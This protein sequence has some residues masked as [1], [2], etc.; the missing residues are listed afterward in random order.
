MARENIIVI[1][2]SSKKR[3]INPMIYSHFI[4]HIGDC[5]HNGIWTYDPV[6]VPLVK[7]NP[8]LTGVRQDLLQ[9][10]KNLKI[11]VL[12]WPG[13]CYSDVYHWKDAIGS[14]E[15]RKMVKN[16]F[17]RDRVLKIKGVGP[18]T[19]RALALISDLIY[20]EKPSWSDPVKFSF[21]VGGKDGVPFPVDRK[22]MDESTEIIRQGIKQAKIGDEDKIKALRRLK[23]FIPEK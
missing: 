5:I 9:A 6:N 19:V 1:D 23:K 14:R 17:W 22:A 16:K 3:L 11:N 10:I 15:T 20:G 8:R 7:G 4:E 13:G 18:N 21:T 12:R 2:V